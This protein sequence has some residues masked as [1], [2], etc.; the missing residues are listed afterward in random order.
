MIPNQSSIT[1]ENIRPMLIQ[2]YA[3]VTK[4]GLISIEG[5]DDDIIFM[6]EDDTRFDVVEQVILTDWV[7][8]DPLLPNPELDKALWEM[9]QI[10]AKYD[11]VS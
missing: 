1:Y 2:T 7:H 10:F 8:V 9:I 3:G 11:P 6:I 4:F 5:L